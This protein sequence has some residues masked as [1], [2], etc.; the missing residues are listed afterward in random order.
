MSQRFASGETVIARDTFRPSPVLF[1]IKTELSVTEKRIMGRRANTVL[2]VIPLGSTEMVFPLKQVS[3]VMVSTVVKPMRVIIGVL[4]FL[5][6]LA[7]VT[8]AL[9]V[10]A[11][12]V[13]AAVVL[14]GLRAALVIMNNAG[15]RQEIVVTLFEKVR[16]GN[17]A[18]EVQQHL[19]DL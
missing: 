10:L 13:G 11:V 7:H 1:W 3:S 4:L 2:G 12:L 6:G 17:F 14:G 5:I 15:G 9:G 19:L 8:S 16:L 18:S